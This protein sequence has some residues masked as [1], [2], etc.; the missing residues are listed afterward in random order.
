MRAQRYEARQRVASRLLVVLGAEG[1]VIRTRPSGGWTSTQFRWAPLANWQPGVA[2][3]DV[4]G[5]RVKLAH[6]WL[7]AFG[8]ATVEDLRWWAGWSL[9]Q[10]RDAL[11]ALDV[12]E[13]DLGGTT[14]VLAGEDAEPVAAGS[15]WAALLPALDSTTMGWRQRDWYLGDHGPELFDSNGNAGPTV[16]WDGRV[17]GG[18]A[19]VPG[20]EIR[21]ELL[22]DC[23]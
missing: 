23:R 6:A 22:D 2:E 16:W 12:V 15:P 4:A 20:G 1:R 11:A 10:A 8:P 21:V 14:G 7:L 9:G 18:W 3:H 5:A 13:V 17:V 19:Q